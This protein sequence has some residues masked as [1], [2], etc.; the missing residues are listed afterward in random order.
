MNRTLSATL[1]LDKMLQ[2]LLTYFLLR[3]I[4]DNA[5]EMRAELSLAIGRSETHVT[6]WHERIILSPPDT[7]SPMHGT[8]EE[9]IDVPIVEKFA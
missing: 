8:V 7:E 2:P 3:Y 4:S 9:P 5:E 6:E 1:L